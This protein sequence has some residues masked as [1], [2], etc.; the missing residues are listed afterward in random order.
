[1]AGYSGTPLGKKLG[2]K[3]DTSVLLVEMPPAVRKELS[4]DLA[5]VK[6]VKPSFAEID[7]IHAFA[8]S[9]AVLK[10][11]LPSWKK[12]LSK[13]G[14]L[15]IS[16]PK[17]TSSITSDLSG[18]IVRELGLG[19]GLVDIKVCAVDEHWSGLKFVFRKSDR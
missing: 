4:K 12:A 15:W 9:K 10:K 16:W 2:I 1:M 14:A 18:D 7:L 17:K 3:P 8:S 5:A 11:G 6:L 19:V 13:S